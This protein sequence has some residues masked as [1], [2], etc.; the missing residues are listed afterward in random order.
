M[1]PSTHKD[2]TPDS[3]TFNASNERL[4]VVVL[5]RVEIRM[6]FH[7]CFY[8]SF[9]R[10]GFVVYFV[11]KTGTKN[12]FSYRRQTACVCVCV[13]VGAHVVGIVYKNNYKQM[14]SNILCTFCMS[15][16]CVCMMMMM[17]MNTIHKFHS[18]PSLCITMC[19]CCN[20]TSCIVFLLLFFCCVPNSRCHIQFRTHPNE[21]IHLPHWCR[22]ESIY[23]GSLSF[24][25]YFGRLCLHFT[26]L[27][28]EKYF[29]CL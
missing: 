5:A 18:C 21:R 11:Q 27:C 29:V 14:E 16:Q 26:R 23:Y 3:H 17:T 7:V 2:F 22:C 20:S 4:F 6:K 28:A 19:V 1:S 10:S 12:N 8:F 24:F 9:V 15:D 25:L 13:F